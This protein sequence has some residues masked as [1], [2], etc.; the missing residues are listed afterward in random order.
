MASRKEQK[1]Q[2]RQARIEAEQAA[3]KQAQQRRLGIMAGV[4]VI[5]AII[6]AVVIVIASSNTKKNTVGANETNLQTGQKSQKTYKAVAAELKG[7]PQ[8]GTTLGNPKAKVT[9]QY[10]GDLQCPV[11]QAFTLGNDGGGLPQLI[12]GPVKQGKVKLTYRSFCTATGCPQ[13]QSTFNSQQVAAEAA[14][15]QNLFWDYAELFYHEQGK[16]DSGYVTPTFLTGIAKQIPSLKLSQWNKD[17]KDTK[18]AAQVSADNSAATADKIQGTP[19]L[20]ASGPGGKV[21]QV[22]AATGI[23]SYSE[24][25]GAIQNVS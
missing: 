16:E 14:G 18:L 21:T 3:Q 12:S 19:S 6:A 9:L 5:A 22:P 8:H 7:I 25:T 24:L 1:E 10:F 15:K 4:V 2:A 13:N 20:I 11:C 17:R 23:P